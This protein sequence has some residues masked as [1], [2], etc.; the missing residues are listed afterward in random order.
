MFLNMIAVLMPLMVLGTSIWVFIDSREIGR[1]RKK[2]PGVFV[3][4]PV[5]WCVA[6][7]LCWSIFF[8]AY[9]W[10]RRTHKRTIA[11]AMAVEKPPDVLREADLITQLGALADDYTEGR[12]TMQEFKTRKEA[13]VHR[14]T[15][16]S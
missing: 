12:L 1:L 3:L 5:G 11:M 16:P 14:M 6:C 9:L 7:L 4:G 15:V 13:L 10:K 8:P 2:T